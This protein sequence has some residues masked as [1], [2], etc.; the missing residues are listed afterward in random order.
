MK[1]DAIFHHDDWGTQISTFMAPAMFEEFL[2][3]PYK[4]GVRLLQEPRRAVSRAPLDSFGETL[5]PYMIEMGIDIWQ[6]T[7]KATNDIPRLIDEYGGRISF[8]GGIESQVV[9]KPDWTDEEAVAE[10]NRALDAVN[11]TKHFLL[12]SGAE[13]GG[14]P[15]HTSG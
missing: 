9:D 3:E 4:Q 13:T 2:L 14:Y 11:R 15:E 1:P 5:V 10:V 6:G 12:T 8:M 7:L